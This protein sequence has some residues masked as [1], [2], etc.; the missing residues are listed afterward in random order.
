[1]EAEGIIFLD[2]WSLELKETLLDDINNGHRKVEDWANKVG[3]G[4]YRD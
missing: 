3:S 1:M 4:N 2:L